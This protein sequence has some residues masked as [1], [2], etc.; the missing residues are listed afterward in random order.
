MRDLDTSDIMPARYERVVT[1]IL[2]VVGASVASA[3]A[4]SVLVS[5][6]PDY[7]TQN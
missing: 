3:D 7:V 1:C 2:N 6:R 4:E 5:A